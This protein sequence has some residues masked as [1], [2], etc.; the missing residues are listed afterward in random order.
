VVISVL[1]TQFVCGF[2]D[3]RGEPY[4]GRSGRHDPNVPAVVTTNGAGPHNVQLFVLSADGTVLHCL[5]GYW[6]PQD[7]LYELRF[8][9]TLKPLWENADLP[10]DRKRQL[11]SLATLADIPRHPL[12]MVARSHLQN[13]D[14]KE[15]ENKPDS[16]FR[17]RPGD[18]PPRI[19]MAKHGELKTT[20]QV[21][22]ER[23]A[24]RPFVPYEDFDV[25]QFCD[26]GKFRYDKQEEQREPGA[27]PKKKK[28]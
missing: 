20:D 19:R 16:D 11:G 21:V 14:A 27:P 6:S 2:R 8:A 1:K 28:N 7:L 15:E 22:H 25:A 13:F 10:L 9:L 3:I 12:D 24:R 4:A 17:F 26:Y 23:M 18:Y 5:P